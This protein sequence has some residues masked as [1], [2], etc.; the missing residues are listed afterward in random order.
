M[1]S[2]I[3]FKNAGEIWTIEEDSL[4]NKLY[5]EDMLDIME[6]S[7]IHKRAPGG[8][9]S[10]LIKQKYIS[11]RKSARGYD[12]Y[13]NSELYK[14]IVSNNSTKKKGEELKKQKNTNCIEQDN[15]LISVDKNDYNQLQN[16]VKYIKNEMNIIKTNINELI[17]MIKAVYEFENST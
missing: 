11:E 8:I 9:I 14:K 7:K 1:D 3:E 6:I 5:N 10:R 13:K 12:N 15:I 16:D 4:L 2:E 17:V